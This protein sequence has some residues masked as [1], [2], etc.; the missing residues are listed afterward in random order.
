MKKDIVLTA[1]KTIIAASNIHDVDA[2]YI[3]SLVREN[4][5]NEDDFESGDLLERI[6]AAPNYVLKNIPLDMI[7][8]ERY[9]LDENIVKELG[10]V[11]V[12]KWAPIVLHKIK[13]YSKYDIVD[14][15]HRAN[16]AKRMGLKTI[17]AYV[18]AIY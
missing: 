8:T 14:G 10:K 16:A 3:E 11:D 9:N 1:L 7:D 12:K 2:F 17:R 4:H 6:Y 5:S 18:G 15:N 13:G